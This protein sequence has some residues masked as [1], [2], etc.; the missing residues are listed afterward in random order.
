[1]AGIF[2]SQKMPTTKKIEISQFHGTLLQT[3][4]PLSAFTL[5]GT[6]NQL[7][8]NQRLQ[9]HWTFMFFGFTS[10]GY[11]CPTTLAE[12]AKMYKLLKAQKIK[13]MPEVVLVSIDPSRDSLDR[14]K[15]Y[16][17]SF[18]P[19]FYG[20]RG[21]TALIKPLTKELG[22]VY[23]KV[24][25]LV[26]KEAYDIQHSGTIILL[27]PKGRVA[28]FFTSPHQAENLVQDYQLLVS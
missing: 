1:M 5:M 22:V 27:D 12:L 21:E 24:P 23:A 20:A 28:A 10:C 13:P 18:N 9:G 15:S 7:F 3:P 4:R 17:A 6:D 11:L 19:N 2:F 16:T 14:L 26:N 25:A 8:N